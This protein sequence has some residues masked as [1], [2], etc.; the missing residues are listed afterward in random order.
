MVI[1]P[2]SYMEIGKT[3]LS[4]KDRLRIIEVGNYLCE[5]LEGKFEGIEFLSEKFKISPTKLKKD[6]KLHYGKSLF[7]Y[8]QFQQMLFANKLLKKEDL[9]IKELA[10]RMGYENAGKFSQAFKKHN[11][12]LPSKLIKQ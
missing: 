9:R 11:G 12:E 5:N 2:I 1:E 7:S 4:E 3:K 6:F 8:Y 10:V